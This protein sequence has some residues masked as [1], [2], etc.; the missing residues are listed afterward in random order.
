MFSREVFL[1]GDSHRFC[2]HCILGDGFCGLITCTPQPPGAHMDPE[3]PPVNHHLG[4]G[5]LGVRQPVP[6]SMVLGLLLGMKPRRQ[7][8]RGGS[9]AHMQR[10]PRK[11]PLNPSPLAL[12]PDSPFSMGV[13]PQSTLKWLILVNLFHSGPKSFSAVD[14]IYFGLPFFV[15]LLHMCGAPVGSTSEMLHPLA[16]SREQSQ[17]RGVSCSQAQMVPAGE[18]TGSASPPPALAAGTRPTTQ[19]S[20]EIR[21]R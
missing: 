4:P 1:S 3:T 11:R 8:S 9:T 17:P 5:P 13:F 12:P 14:R 21:Q 20:F 2:L 6:G 19:P 7:W 10:K 16:S 18:G 15:C